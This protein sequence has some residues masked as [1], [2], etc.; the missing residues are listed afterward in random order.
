MATSKDND[1]VVGRWRAFFAAFF[2]IF[3]R[4]ARGRAGGGGVPPVDL[5]GESTFWWENE[6]LR[7]AILSLRM[8]ANKPGESYE[9]I[10]ARV[11]REAAAFEAFRRNPT[12]IGKISLNTKLITPIASGRE[13]LTKGYEVF[14]PDKREASVDI[15]LE[16]S[17]RL[18][19]EVIVH[20]EN[21]NPLFPL[22]RTYS[23]WVGAKSFDL[24]LGRTFNLRMT[25]LAGAEAVRVSAGFASP[26]GA[27]EQFELPIAAYTNGSRPDVADGFTWGFKRFAFFRCATCLAIAMLC[28][29]MV[30]NALGSQPA[31]PR[32]VVGKASGATTVYAMTIG[33]ANFSNE[34][35]TVAAPEPPPGSIGTKT[36]KTI[37][38]SLSDSHP[39]NVNHGAR[40]TDRKC[41][42]LVANFRKAVGDIFQFA[43]FP[44]Q[45]SGSHATAQTREMTKESDDALFR[46]MSVTFTTT[47]G[48]MQVREP[49]CLR[50]INGKADGL[51][52]SAPVLVTGS[53]ATEP[54]D[55]GAPNDSTVTKGEKPEEAALKVLDSE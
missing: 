7:E 34:G 31:A 38:A 49:G 33:F 48:L 22:L 13:F 46:H 25:Q 15:T 21:E 32:A 54:T 45:G 1:D 51:L 23:D 3:N 18:V 35:G 39:L 55:G 28:S 29:W 20:D 37:Q 47:D 43:P 53:R 12:P 10:A 50:Y 19:L 16:R 4:P 42:E 5:W 11:D 36:F 26:Q 6:K 27:V 2:K 14:A 44:A 24:G 8:V 41:G 17:N 9:E 52:V 30:F 40:E